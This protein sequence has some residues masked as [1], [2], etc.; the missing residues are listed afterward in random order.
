MASFLVAEV[1]NMAAGSSYARF[2]IR[3]YSWNE[4]LKRKRIASIW[5]AHIED[6]GELKGK[7]SLFEDIIV[8]SKLR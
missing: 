1:N 5:M 3:L 8:F 4:D 2:S 6:I 7:K